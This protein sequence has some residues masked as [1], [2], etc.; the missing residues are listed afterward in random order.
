GRMAVPKVGLQA[1]FILREFLKNQKKYQ[2][3]LKDIDNQTKKTATSV[4]KSTASMAKS[5]TE[6]AN[7]SK[8]LQELQQVVPIQKY[9]DQ[10]TELDK[11][12][13]GLGSRAKVNVD[14]FDELANSG[15]RLGDAL[16]IAGKGLDFNIEKFGEAYDATT[17][18]DLALKAGL[19]TLG[20]TMSTVASATA[21]FSAFSLA[22]GT[23]IKIIKE[24][25]QQYNDLAEQVRIV[26]LELGITTEEAQAWINRATLA[27]TPTTTLTT[28]LGNLQR[29]ITDT[30]LRMTEGLTTSTQF[31][32]A[33]K[34][35]GLESDLTGKN[36]RPTT[37][38]MDDMIERMRELGS[39][40]AT[41]EVAMAVF[42]RGAKTLLPL[43][44]E[45]GATIED[46]QEK[47]DKYGAA[48]E[49]NEV[50][51][52]RWKEATLELTIAKQGIANFFA[53]TFIPILSDVIE[54]VAEL[55]N[56][57]RRASIVGQSFWIGLA[58]AVNKGNLISGIAAAV[59]HYKRLH[60]VTDE[61]VE[62][63]L[64]LALA[65]QQAIFDTLAAAEAEEKL[66]EQRE[67][68]LQDLEDLQVRFNEKLADI[69]TDFSDRWQDILID[70]ARDAED[71]TIEMF[72][73]LEDIWRKNQRKLEDIS[74]RG[75]NRLRDVERDRSERVGDF[76]EQSNKKRE[77]LELRHQERLFKIQTRF[78]DTVQE[79][80][81][82][83]DAVAVV[84]AIRRRNREV[85]DAERQRRVEQR[86]LG[87]D[88]D[89]RRREIN[90]GRS[91]STVSSRESLGRF[92]DCQRTRETGDT[93]EIQTAGTGL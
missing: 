93:T 26:R 45:E 54:K 59:E 25:I 71:Q 7:Q 88:L 85:R 13:Q 9:I 4:T 15:V 22:V 77:D 27:G 81:R 62:K 3:A 76:Q 83:N 87:R 17:N 23:S 43:L 32:R 90:R 36:I 39:G 68:A 37:E 40:A 28:A 92:C 74:I 24:S 64:K 63:E 84:A 60:D 1:E 18:Y 69:E 86:D 16:N 55:V 29:N 21:A 57:I 89:E 50:L 5:F 91:T 53:R 80:A 73:K 8:V 31:T 35:L 82:R 52:Q 65:R 49:E 48:I 30:R 11:A 51:H 33:M 75:T 34:L 47:M 19:G 12:F 72:Q 67:K 14:Q 78:L 58:A 10:A 6:F 41:T 79:A 44:L 46:I 70:R 20:K 61:S 2:K 66:R 42:G 56:W 38:I